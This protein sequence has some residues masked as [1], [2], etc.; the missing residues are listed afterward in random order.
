MHKESIELNGQLTFTTRFILETIKFIKNRN[1]V[2]D[3]T[4]ELYLEAI[5]LLNKINNSKSLVEEVASRT[6]KIYDSFFEKIDKELNYD[7]SYDEYKMFCEFMRVNNIRLQKPE[8]AIE[9]EKERD[10]KH[11]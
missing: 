4:K 7:F 1:L 10:K 5:E 6:S 2:K 8:I 11:D 9:W 3:I